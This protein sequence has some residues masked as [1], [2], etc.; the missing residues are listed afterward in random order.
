M[1]MVLV[2]L[3]PMPPPPMLVR[4]PRQHVGESAEPT[5]QPGQDAKR[6]TVDEVLE[7]DDVHLEHLAD[8]RALGVL[9]WLGGWL[10]GL[11]DVLSRA[12]Y[13]HWRRRHRHK[14]HEDH[15]HS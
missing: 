7:N 12:P 6:A 15:M 10:G 13:E 5:A 1:H 14:P 4:R 9:P 11:S 8:C 2:R 3:V